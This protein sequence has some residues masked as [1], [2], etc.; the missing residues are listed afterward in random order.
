MEAAMPE[1]RVEPLSVLRWRDAD[2]PARD[3]LL[4]RGV[5]QIFDPALRQSIASIIDDVREHGDEAVACA[6]ERFDGCK[7][8][9]GALRVSAREF[10][11]ARASVGPELQDAVRDAIANIR[12]FNQA[13]LRERD[14]RIELRRCCW[15]R[16][17]A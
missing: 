17:R 2:E 12:A 7:V 15:G 13:A 9:P 3:R 14:W 6:L 4:G 10:E 8:D 11:L 5:G 1:V 16:P